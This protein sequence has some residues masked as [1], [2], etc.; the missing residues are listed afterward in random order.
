[1]NESTYLSLD[2]FIE[3]CVILMILPYVEFFPCEI[4][5]LPVA[6]AFDGLE[7]TNSN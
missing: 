4:M 6:D 3:K 7:I 5:F 2:A 1:M